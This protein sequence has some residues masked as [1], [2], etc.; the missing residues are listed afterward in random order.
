MDLPL[1]KNFSTEVE[2]IVIWKGKMMENYT[3]RQSYRAK[4]VGNRP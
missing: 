4:T 1:L 3:P 2:I